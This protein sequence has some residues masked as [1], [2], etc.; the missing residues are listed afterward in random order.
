[1]DEMDS[2]V[3]DVRGELWDFVQL[4]LDRTPVEIF[5]PGMEKL[6]EIA[7]R[8]A[9]APIVSGQRCRQPSGSEPTRKIVNLNLR[10]I[11][12]KAGDRGVR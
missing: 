12:V 3:I 5:G 6:L 4:R 1:M 7:T 8:Y 11:D 2:L 10:D 9:R